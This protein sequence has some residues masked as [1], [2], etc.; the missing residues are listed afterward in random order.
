MF[1]NY[2]NLFEFGLFVF[3]KKDL[4]V[5][6]FSNLLEVRGRLEIIRDCFYN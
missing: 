5:F 4:L 3:Y 6:L 2:Y 1:V